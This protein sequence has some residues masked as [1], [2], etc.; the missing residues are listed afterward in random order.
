MNE[1]QDSS[2]GGLLLCN[3]HLFDCVF[4]LGE[5]GSIVSGA[6]F[7]LG[8]G[9]GKEYGDSKATGNKWDWKDIVADLAGIAF[10]VL[11]LAIG[12]HD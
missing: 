10:A 4:F 2:C 1:R 6:C 9:F 7:A 8:L 12:W 11:V 5:V 3:H